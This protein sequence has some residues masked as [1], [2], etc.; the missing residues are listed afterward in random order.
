MNVEKILTGRKIRPT[1]VRRN[2]LK[3]LTREARPLTAGEIIS[4]QKSKAFDRV[5]VYRTLYTLAESGLVH[6]VQGLDGAWRFCAH[7]P[8]EHGCPGNHP[9]FLC[10]EC[11]SMR[12]LT[13]QQLPWVRV[14][15]D[16]EV[17]GKQL[18]VYGVCSS[19]ARRVERA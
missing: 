14:P 13:E 4:L 19:C 15:T 3:L 17:E 10:R 1:P 8:A 12:C 5:T 16:V 2:L 9:H 11:G 18:V 6:R 7:P